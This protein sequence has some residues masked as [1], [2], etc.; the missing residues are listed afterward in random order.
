MKDEI[1]DEKRFDQLKVESEI[2]DADEQLKALMTRMNTW[3]M[4]EDDPSKEKVGIVSKLKKLGPV[5]L[6]QS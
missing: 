5:K 1:E 6:K 2:E 4:I 3:E